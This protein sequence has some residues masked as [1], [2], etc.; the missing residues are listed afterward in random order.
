MIYKEN[1]LFFALIS[2]LIFISRWLPSYYL[3]DETTSV[4]VILESIT[5]GYLYFPL[6]KYLSIFDFNNSFD[7][8]HTNLDNLMLPF[9]SIVIHSFFYKLFGSFSFILVEF[10]SIFIFLIIIFNLFKRFYSKEISILFS[11]IIFSLPVIVSLLPISEFTSLRIIKDDIFSL[12]FPRPIITTLYLFFFIYLISSFENKEFLNKKNSFVLGTI[13][14]FTLSSF[15]YFFFLQVVIIFLYLLYRY[16]KNFLK[17]LLINLK[18]MLIM[19]FTFLIFSIPLIINL[20]YNESDYSQRLGIININFE[21]KMILMKYFFSR[22]LKI[23]FLFFFIT[24]SIYIFYIN[25]RKIK[26]YRFINLFYLFFVSSVIT[27][28]F[29][30]LITTKTG[31]LYHYNN[32]IVIFA[33]LLI[34]IILFNLFDKISQKLFNIKII[35]ILSALLIL[36]CIS[37]NFLKMY[38]NTDD[39]IKER[40]EFNQVSNLILKNHDLSESTLMTFDNRFMVWS[41]LNDIKF[42]NL[43]NFIMTPKKDKMIEDDLIKTLKFL[44]FNSNDFSS[45]IANKKT[46]WRYM[47]HNLSTFFFY[48]YIANPVTTYNNSKDFDPEVYSYILKSSPILF[49]QSIIPNY[50]LERLNKKFNYLSIKNFNNPNIIIINKKSKFIK[51]ELEIKNYCRVFDK[52]FFILMFQKNK[53]TNC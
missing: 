43:T 7:P 47:N 16:K 8:N 12:R 17:K 14:A 31:I 49:E 29:F 28:L 1:I 40:S 26:N 18:S 24:S 51:K 48:K 45:F 21:Q 11:I 35:N 38:S 2:F 27:P 10:F 5:D 36:I 37:T 53:K 20:F 32:T 50:E 9:Y 15:Y 25:N 52:D 4:K 39:K 41:V 33:F 44:D 13:F 19:I 34:L 46:S 6:V 30:I 42:L 3:F 22:F 23:E